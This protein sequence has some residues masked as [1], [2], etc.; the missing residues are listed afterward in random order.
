MRLLSNGVRLLQSKAAI[1]RHTADTHG[2]QQIHGTQQTQEKVTESYVNR[3]P[4]RGEMRKHV[5][6]NSHLVRAS[7]TVVEQS[8]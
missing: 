3:F 5:K 2:T 1:A 6:V 7:P 4:V 8:N